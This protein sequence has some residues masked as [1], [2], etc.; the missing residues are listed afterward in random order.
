M[1]EIVWAVNPK[2]DSLDSL[3][4]YL[5]GFAQNFLSTAGIRCRLDEPA[6]LP[7]WTLTAETRHN[8]FLAFK[9]A[10]H[11]VVKHA[12][13]SE[14]RVSLE[15]LPSSFALTIADNGSGFELNGFE[16]LRSDDASLK[17]SAAAGG[18]RGAS[19][20][21][22]TDGVPA[23]GGDRLAAGNGL[24]NMRKRLEEIGGGFRLDSA[25]G[26]GTRVRLAVKVKK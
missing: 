8:V 16:G 11:N 22:P 20:P 2:H 19:M 18:R 7:V 21:K 23:S 12:R 13:A 15:L 3:V 25:V 24:L 4:T 17:I 14:V 1:D 5:G 10:L 9:E 26:E 6:H